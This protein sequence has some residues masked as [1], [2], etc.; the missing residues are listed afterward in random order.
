MKILLKNELNRAFKNKWLLITLIVCLVIIVYDICVEIIP[1]RVA[2]DGYINTWGYPVPNLYNR[3]MEMNNSTATRI[4]HLVF[5]LLVCIPYSVTLHSDIKTKYSYNIFIHADKKYYFLAKLITQFVVGFTVVMITLLTSFILTAAILPIGY[6]FPGSSYLVSGNSVMGKG[7]YE[8]P[9]L[10][11][12]VVMIAEAIIFAIIGCVSFVFAYILDNGIV[13]MISPFT[14]YFFEA[15]IAPLIG[16]NNR[17]MECT[18]V[19]KLT[20]DAILPFIVE[21]TFMVVAVLI[22]YFIRIHKKDEL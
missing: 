17:M 19:I 16:I 5:P 21:L 11:S 9:L 8:Y 18:S 3:W 10:I 13:V 15:V 14:L 22:A 2:L 12:L 7:F 6:P 1:T 20:Y 4:F